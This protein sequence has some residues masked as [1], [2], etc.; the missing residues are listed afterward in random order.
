MKE[1]AGEGEGQEIQMCIASG[2]VNRGQL[3]Y[4][5]FFGPPLTMRFSF[6]CHRDDR[7]PAASFKTIKSESDDDE[8][9]FRVGQSSSGS[10]SEEGEDSDAD[11]ALLAQ[12]I[13]TAAANMPRRPT[14]KELVDD[15]G[16]AHRPIPLPPGARGEPLFPACTMLHR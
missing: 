16:M 11:A 14:I 1:R 13:A 3:H 12:E 8:D 9:A 4:N 7:D 2:R 6:L 15:L 5:P 10:G